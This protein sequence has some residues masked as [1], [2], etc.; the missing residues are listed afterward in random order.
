MLDESTFG[1]AGPWERWEGEA[2]GVINSCMIL[3][4]EAND[5][6]RPVF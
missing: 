5:V 2:G 6:V 3:T 4:T 1:F